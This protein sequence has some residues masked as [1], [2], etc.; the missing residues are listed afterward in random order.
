M[1]STIVAPATYPAESA[2]GVI[3]ISGPET[4]PV[5]KKIFKFKFFKN[6]FDNIKSHSAH[7]GFIKDKENIIDE[8]L[9]IVFKS[10]KSYTGED[11]AE[12]SCHGN[13]FI[14]NKI[15][16][17]LI[18]N[19][20]K[21]AEHGEFTKRAFLNGKISLSEAEA[22]AD[23]VSSKNDISLNLALKQLLG[24]EKNLI[25]NLREKIINVI[26]LIE[27]DLD[28]S[29]SVE[30]I[31]KNKIKNL[32][33]DILE[34]INKLIHS[35]DKG[36]MLKQGIKLVITGK[37]NVGKSSLLNSLL[38][39]EKAIVTHIP[40][41]TRDIIEDTVNIEGLPFKIYDTAGI[42]KAKGLIEKKGIEKTIKTIKTSDLVLFLIDGS[43]KL[44]KNDFNIFSEVKRKNFIIVIN[45]NDLKLKY[46]EEKISDIFKTEKN[47][48]VTISALKNK[49][50]KNLTKM[51]KN[52]IINKDNFILS[53]DIV[54]SNLRHKLALKNAAQSL[55]KAIK[56]LNAFEVAIIDIKNAINFIDG[57][58]GKITDEHILDSIFK[59]FCIGK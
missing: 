27:T 2:I 6:N 34:T 28:F 18:K 42:R 57:I 23:M 41:T 52:I 3:R 37:P 7:L 44:D 30:N 20:C 38:K 45:K 11:M 9:L 17:L 22:V 33:N 55:K 8:V 15:L 53:G 4:F 36:I 10:P 5:L 13:P 59:N 12:I 50:I 39:K 49:G 54:I 35:A 16:E 26:S 24:E 40:G 14:I 31:E 47:R 21:M 43:R 51:I 1:N 58:I 19:G 32:L 25:L 56:N 48:I 46:T 29:D